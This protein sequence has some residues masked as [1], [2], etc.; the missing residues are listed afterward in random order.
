M[1]VVV[2]VQDVA[3]QLGVKVM[4]LHRCGQLPCQPVAFAGDPG[5]Q[6]VAG[7]VGFDD[8]PLNDKVAVAFEP[9]ISRYGGWRGDHAFFVNL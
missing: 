1:A 5:L 9:R 4:A 6:P 2:L 3:A 7:V 8:Q